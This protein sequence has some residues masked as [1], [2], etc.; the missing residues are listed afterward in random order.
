[1]N[2]RKTLTAEQQIIV[3]QFIETHN[4]DASQISFEGN[5]TTPIFDYEAVNALS[6][7][8]TDIKNIECEIW[9]RDFEGGIFTARCIVTLPDGRSRTCYDSAS[10]NEQIASGTVINT[11]RLAENVA[12]ARAVRRGVRSVG[13]N[14]FRA[15]QEFV[16]NGGKPVSAHTNNDPR[17]P[18]YVEIHQLAGNV[19]LIVNSDKTEY[20]RYIAENFEGCTSAKD[21][22]D[23]DL[24]RLLVQLRA[25][26]RLQKIR[27]QNA[28][29]KPAAA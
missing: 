7:R 25:W 3:Q 24:H 10:V 16:K 28:Q 20:Q 6:L 17:Q 23:M 11:T 21:L 5:D 26:N 19:G 14:L 18:H 12:Q 29:I 13:I 1:M 22:N 2:E 4:L 15:H 27:N 9:T 8:L